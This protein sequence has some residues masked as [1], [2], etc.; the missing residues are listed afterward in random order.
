ML[1]HDLF[2]SPGQKSSIVSSPVASGA[3]L[4]AASCFESPEY[5]YPRIFLVYGFFLP[6]FF[7]F[8]NLMPRMFRLVEGILHRV[9][10]NLSSQGW[11]QIPV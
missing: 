11:P 2:L 10:K 6:S 4:S 8:F 3:T 1:F 7:F 5:S 9:R